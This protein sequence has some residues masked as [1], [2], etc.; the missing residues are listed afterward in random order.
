MEVLGQLGEAGTGGGEE[1]KRRGGSPLFG[2][3]LLV[4]HEGEDTKKWRH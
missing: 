1:K 4:G 3:S 2:W